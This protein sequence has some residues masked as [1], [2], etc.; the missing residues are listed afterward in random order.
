MTALL[1]LLA[2][3]EP[4]G[5]GERWI[6]Y[7]S[8]WTWKSGEGMGGVTSWSGRF[9][10][11]AGEWFFAERGAGDAFRW[12]GAVRVHAVDRGGLW[13]GRA[14]D[15][16]GRPPEGCPLLAVELPGSDDLRGWTWARL[17]PLALGAW[18][19]ARAEEDTILELQG[20]EPRSSPEAWERFERLA[21]SAAEPR[22]RWPAE[23]ET[24]LSTRLPGHD[25][26]RLA[27][28]WSVALPGRPA[29]DDAAARSLRIAWLLLE[30]PKA[31]DAAFAHQR[32]SAWSLAGASVSEWTRLEAPAE[33]DV[34]GPAVVRVRVRGAWD[35]EGGGTS[36]TRPAAVRVSVGAET[37]VFRRARAAD[38]EFS[39]PPGRVW[40]TPAETRV[41]VPPGLHRVSVAAEGEG[42]VAVEEWRRIHQGDLP[43]PESYLDVA[44]DRAE[45]NAARALLEGRPEE[46]VALLACAE[47]AWAAVRGL[48]TAVR[49]GWREAAD[50][51][52]AR[53]PW[54]ALSGAL[55]TEARLAGLRH[56]IERGRPVEADRHA[57]ALLRDPWATPEDCAEA[58]L[59]LDAGGATTRPGRA[60]A[61]ADDPIPP[62]VLR[63]ML[64]DFDLET[65]R[66]RASRWHPLVPAVAEAAALRR[67]A[68]RVGFQGPRT[69]LWEP[70]AR[71]RA[72]GD[73]GTWRASTAEAARF[74]AATRGMLEILPL[75]R[76]AVEAPLAIFAGERP[77]GLARLKDPAS[78]FLLSWT[79]VDPESAG[80]VDGGDPGR[81]LLWRG[82][83]LAWPPGD[84]GD[85]I[86]LLHANAPAATA[87]AEFAT[88][89]GAGR[90]IARLLVEVPESGPDVDAPFQAR[91][92]TRGLLAARLLRVGAGDPAV[93]AARVLLPAAAVRVR[94]EAPAGAI[95]GLDERLNRATPAPLLTDDY[96]G[97][98]ARR[99]PPSGVLELMAAP[100]RLADPREVE[101][102]GRQA[103]AERGRARGEAL[104]RRA[105][106]M[107]AAD[108][109]EEAERDLQDAEAV[110]AAEDV[111]SD[112]AQR[113]RIRLAAFAFERGRFA[114]L[115]TRLR[116]IFVTGGGSAEA[117]L[118]AAASALAGGDPAAAAA[119]AEA[120]RRHPSPRPADLESV[121]A[122]S[123]GDASGA[124]ARDG[125]LDVVTRLLRLR[126]L[127]R[128][129]DAADFLRAL[130]SA[131]AAIEAR[132]RT[133]L[134]AERAERLRRWTLDAE[135]AIAAARSAGAWP[136][137]AGVLDP[138][139]VLRDV[140]LDPAGSGAREAMMIGASGFRPAWWMAAGDEIRLPVVAPGWYE[141]EWRSGFAEGA[142]LAA[143]ARYWIQG[144]TDGP[145][146]RTV[147]AGGPARDLAAPALPGAVPGTS[148]RRRFA[149]GAGESDDLRLRVLAGAGFVALRTAVAHAEAAWGGLGFREAAA[150]AP[151]AP[152]AR[153]ADPRPDDD[154]RLDLDRRARALAQANEESREA[155]ADDLLFLALT[156]P[157]QVDE[158]EILR[159][160]VLYEGLP[161]APHRD[162]HLA[163]AASLTRWRYTDLSDRF[164]E[165]RPA[166]SP[167]ETSRGEEGSL[168]AA[169]FLPLWEGGLVFDSLAPM[170]WRHESPRPEFVKVEIVADAI[171][172]GSVP[173][174]AVR[175]EV[176]GILA[177]EGALEPGKPRTFA[178]SLPGDTLL[179]ARVGGARPDAIVR[180]RMRVLD[181]EGRPF[182]PSSGRV[183]LHRSGTRPVE[184]T[185]L[186]P[187]VVRF[188]AWPEAR[189]ARVGGDAWETQG[190]PLEEIRLLESRGTSVAAFP[191]PD[192]SLFRLGARVT[193]VDAW[194]R[195]LA[196]TPKAPAPGRLAQEEPAR[197]R[198][199]V[200]ERP[201]PVAR[202]I[203]GLPGLYEAFAAAEYRG[204]SSKRDLDEEDERDQLVLGG[205]FH[206]GGPDFYARMSI[207]EILPED[208]PLVSSGELR[209]HHYFW[210]RPDLDWRLIAE[211]WTQTING[212]SEASWETRARLRWR[213][214]PVADQADLFVSGEVSWWDGTLEDEGVATILEDVYRRL[215]NDYRD[216]HRRWGLYEAR[217]RYFPYQNVIVEPWTYVRSNEDF[218]D[219][220]RWAAGLD[221]K[222]HLESWFAD[223][224]FRYIFR[225]EDDDRPSNEDETSLSART[226]WQGWLGA[227]TWLSIEL[228]GTWIG[229][230]NAVEV[231][232]G[233]VLRFG[234]ARGEKLLEVD[235]EIQRFRDYQDA[236]YPWRRP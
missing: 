198:E 160:V 174:P 40:T 188:E 214:V 167:L 184:A 114:E 100:V 136:P 173:D 217:L 233:L 69:G 185:F 148:D 126:Q 192:G 180:A 109:L 141:V 64:L 127:S 138:L 222:G 90:G 89:G 199:D 57:E 24:D 20:L 13:I 122:A 200:D 208:Q 177:A 42:W 82:R 154:P 175:I 91:A 193:D 218:A 165:I 41:A 6:R 102:D 38:L 205:R 35:L 132:A 204:R 162:R 155:V 219:P 187:T 221:V 46:A 220:D 224:G 108:L 121:L 10:L 137:P 88:L 96:E 142:A 125:F 60:W 119:W 110:F 66:S 80:R 59:A 151:P 171:P 97:L 144:L 210:S 149:L 117:Y 131:R 235:P 79:G 105:E 104:L 116:K 68:E 186:G 211:G 63:R 213:V 209:L 150:V 234:G 85:W 28:R 236:V 130:D 178:L 118:L 39:G 231:G 44:T 71:F 75:D 48:E 51:F 9:T 146:T 145:A 14:P 65:V 152:P 19:A 128:E 11:R 52:D 25:V 92:G 194:R 98:E 29:D 36:N 124:P 32:R 12:K 103:L 99:C 61:V 203:E 62:R 115:R 168:R 215:W 77:L 1:L 179:V 191:P 33:R 227:G 17:D 83:A 34:E 113:A 172:P 81:V 206:V 181:E 163:M 134:R 18:I 153:P 26:G 54:D 139:A 72:S 223:I 133:E 74:R 107:A 43:R 111:G 123:I 27:R 78:P 176:D 70:W 21:R 112:G 95:V 2:L 212:E 84:R 53:V 189:V 23:L 195:R 5:Y 50:H 106:K 143:P 7:A 56:A 15:P 55:A 232:F 225:F 67:W 190:A 140:T 86:S 207:A 47:G 229:P 183:T 169:L 16:P 31:R 230:E 159:A 216:E 135:F 158:E 157:E 170:E 101:A 226:G 147:C 87:P 156:R 22:V 182:R 58:L 228:S 129:M 37:I 161:R 196:A 8:G 201:A 94:I 49:I 93:I 164:P 45:L 76:R 30:D 202:E 197:P 3:Q 4:E 166:Y 73:G 120:A